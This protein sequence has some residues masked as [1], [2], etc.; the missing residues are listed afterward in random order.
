MK[1]TESVEKMYN[2]VLR[3]QL[4]FNTCFIKQEPQGNFVYFFFNYV[5]LAYYLH[6]KIKNISTFRNFITPTIVLTPCL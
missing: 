4:L 2:C 5:L 3:Q 6:L 1:F